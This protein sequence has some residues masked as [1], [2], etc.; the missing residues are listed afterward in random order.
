MDFRNVQSETINNKDFEKQYYGTIT[1][2]KTKNRY[3]S[4]RHS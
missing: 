2:M 1:Y 4:V 3:S